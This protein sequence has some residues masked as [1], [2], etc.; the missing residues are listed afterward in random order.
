MLTQFQ[1]GVSDTPPATVF[2]GIDTEVKGGNC[3]TG[4]LSS[5]VKYPHLLEIFGNAQGLKHISQAHLFLNI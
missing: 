5:I 4:F 1:N 3:H 2:R